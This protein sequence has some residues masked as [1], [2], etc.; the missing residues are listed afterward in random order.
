VASGIR[1]ANAKA[2]SDSLSS[3]LIPVPLSP[4]FELKS[5]LATQVWARDEPPVFV[6]TL[7]GE[8]LRQYWNYLP[9]SK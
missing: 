1:N 9:S 6:N 4:D 7:A 8:R 5:L 3:I 2:T